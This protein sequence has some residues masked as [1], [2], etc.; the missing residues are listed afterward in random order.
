[1]C[2]FMHDG[3]SRARSRVVQNSL[4]INLYF[5]MLSS[6]SLQEQEEGAKS[7][8]SIIS[9]RTFQAGK[10]ICTQLHNSTAFCFIETSTVSTFYT[11]KIIRYLYIVTHTTRYYRLMNWGKVQQYSPC[12]EVEG[13]G[14]DLQVWRG[15]EDLILSPPPPPSIVVS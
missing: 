2:Y 4:S 7:G 8:M 15:G 11:K 6:N 9:W 5:H 14:S 10:T 3:S 13:S 12:L 1:M